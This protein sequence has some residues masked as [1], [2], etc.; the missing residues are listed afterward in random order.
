LD[1]G[2]W[3]VESDNVEQG[4]DS[5]AFGPLPDHV[6][7]AVVVCR[8]WPHPSRLPRRVSARHRNGF[9]D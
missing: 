6:V 8:V 7:I 4:T 3:W 1:D 2:R 5:R 9:A